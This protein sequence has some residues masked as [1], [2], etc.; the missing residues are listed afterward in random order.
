MGL[1]FVIISEVLL[2]PLILLLPSNLAPASTINIFVDKSPSRFAL[3]SKF[4]L[5]FA[6]RDPD[7]FPAIVIDSA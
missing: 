2:T 7:T 4:I 3:V 1:G 6:F 5:S